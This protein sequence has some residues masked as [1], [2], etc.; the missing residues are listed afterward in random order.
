MSTRA[1][2]T[3]NDE[4]F[5]FPVILVVLAKAVVV[6]FAFFSSSVSFSLRF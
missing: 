2:A 1:S 5:S 3:K 6:V 4:S